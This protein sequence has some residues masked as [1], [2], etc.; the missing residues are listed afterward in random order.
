MDIVLLISL[1]CAAPPSAPPP[2]PAAA[3][4]AVTPAPSPPAPASPARTGGAL[5]DACE[6]S[7]LVR[8]GDTD[9]SGLDRSALKA[10]LDGEE[11]GAVQFVFAAEGAKDKS[12]TLARGWYASPVKLELKNIPYGE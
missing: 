7:A 1:A 10:L 6:P 8:V 11:D 4:A 5:P 12:Y 2:T 3:P 9:A